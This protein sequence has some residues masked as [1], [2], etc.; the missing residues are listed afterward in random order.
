VAESDHLFVYGTL[1]SSARAARLGARERTRLR[2]ESSSLGPAS[3][4]GRLYDLG[5][6]P[7]LVLS[8][9]GRGLVRGELL[10]LDD[11]AVALSWLDAYE[12][13]APGSGHKEYRRSI[14]QARLASGALVDAWVYEYLG[15]VARA[16][17]VA[18]GRWL[19]R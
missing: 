19:P 10:K 2:R 6:Y 11:P 12:N 7:A 13:A 18:S 8:V 9:G 3:M 5:A 15:S 17:P 4:P 1:M 16:L 14:R